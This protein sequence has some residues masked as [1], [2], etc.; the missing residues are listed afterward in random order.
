MRKLESVSGLIYS[1]TELMFFRR[2]RTILHLHQVFTRKIYEESFTTAA[3]V[4]CY[5]C[6]LYSTGSDFV[7]LPEK[8]KKSERKPWV[9]DINEVKRKARLEKQERGVVR[10]AKLKPPENGLLVKELIPV[11]HDVLAARTRL[12]SCV[13]RVSHSIPIFVC[14]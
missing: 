5:G 9:T 10:E 4:K 1:S 11:A 2:S 7:E 8:L 14:R 3:E 13:S 6:A 12:L